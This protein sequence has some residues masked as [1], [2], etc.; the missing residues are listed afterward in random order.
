[1]VNCIFVA[2]DY[3]NDY[4]GI[5]RIQMEIEQGIF[6]PK[7]HKDLFWIGCSGSAP[8]NY[9]SRP[10]DL[11]RIKMEEKMARIVLPQTQ[12]RYS[13]MNEALLNLVQRE[14][15][16]ALFAHPIDNSSGT[17]CDESHLQFLATTLLLVKRVVILGV[18]RK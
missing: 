15:M 17:G 8:E 18:T 2:Q 1:M 6:D 13:N 9:G 16:V 7:L 10:V 12:S 4:K 5:R 3:K 11:S 14:G